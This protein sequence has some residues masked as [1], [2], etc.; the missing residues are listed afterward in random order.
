MG[1]QRCVAK[2]KRGVP[3]PLMIRSARRHLKARKGLRPDAIFLVARIGV[4]E[5]DMILPAI[6]DCVAVLH[7][8][9]GIFERPHITDHLIGLPRHPKYFDFIPDV[10]VKERDAPVIFPLFYLISNLV[11]PA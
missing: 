5:A 10:N 9:T 6:C 7:F 8:N 4:S 2:I 11:I 3:R 1:A